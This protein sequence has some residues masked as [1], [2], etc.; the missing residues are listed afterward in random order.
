MN[1]AFIAK[2]KLDDMSDL[3]D[4][5][6]EMHDALAENGFEVVE[7]QAWERGEESSPGIENG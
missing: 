1:V 5:A 2:I 4:V 6:D 7:V 3:E